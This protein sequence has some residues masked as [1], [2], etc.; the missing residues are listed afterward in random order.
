MKPAISI[1]NLSK[2]Y[3]LGIIGRQRLVDEVRYWWLRMRGHDPYTYFSKVGHTATEAR[4]VEA[5]REGHE[6]FWAL[7]DVSFDVQPGEVIGIIGRNG[8]G[9]STLLKILT[10][11][12]E[13]TSGEVIIN[14]RVASLL[15]VGTGFHPELTGRENIYMN[16]SIL[17]MKKREIDAKLDEIISFSELEK[18]IDTPVK[19]YSSGMYVR[20]AFAVAA[21]I[22]PEILLVDEVLAV[23]DTEFQKQCLGKMRSVADS[24]RTILFVSHQMNA[25]RTLCSRCIHLSNGEIIFDGDP[26]IA[27]SNYESGCYEM[28]YD[29]ARSDERE[30]FTK[31]WIE[32]CGL[33]VDYTIDDASEYAFIFILHLK[34]TIHNGKIGFV[35]RSSDRMIIYGDARYNVE[36]KP[37]KISIRISLPYLPIRPGVYMLAISLHDDFGK[38]DIWDAVPNLIVKTKPVGHPRDEWSGLLNMPSNWVIKHGNDIINSRQGILI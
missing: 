9:K 5:E 12:T 17:G 2:C 11:I 31:W 30:G 19:R 21:H 28:K 33:N 27:V 32:K 3:K 36:L 37:G 29:D 20:L 13:P 14:G 1:I 24:G 18:F 4:K 16:G 15:E 7:K 26:D 10:R 6:R 25:V 8:T 23:G 35:V 34:R 22:E 38:L